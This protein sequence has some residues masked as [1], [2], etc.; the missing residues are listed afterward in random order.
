MK[1]AFEEQEI[2]I[3][4]RTAILEETNQA[5]QLEIIERTRADTEILSQSRFSEENPNPII[6]FSKA[7]VLL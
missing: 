5:L 6:R 1:K 2:R 3:S 7:E 4:E